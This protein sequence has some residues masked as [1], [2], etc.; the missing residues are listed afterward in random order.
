MKSVHL[1]VPDEQT[2]TAVESTFGPLDA[3]NPT[4]ALTGNGGADA[5]PR[6]CPQPDSE[7]RGPIGRLLA[8]GS[9]GQAV[10]LE[11]VVVVAVDDIIKGSDDD[12]ISQFWVVDPCFPKEGIWVDKWYGDLPEKYAPEKRDELTIQGIFRRINPIASDVNSSNSGR[13]AKTRNAYRPSLKSAFGLPNVSGNLVITKTG[14]VDVPADNTVPAGFGNADGGA[15]AANPEYGGSR[16]HIPGPV[17]ITNANPVALKRRPEDPEHTV[18]LGFEVTGGVLVSNYK[19]FGETL[20]GGTPRCDWRNVVKLTR[21]QTRME[22]SPQI[23][24]V[25]RS[26]FKDWWPAMTI[27]V[28]NG[29][30]SPQARLEIDMWVVPDGTRGVAG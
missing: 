19:T 29:L 2:W 7:G 6:V 8:T 12:F 22:E 30:S 24:A 14:T 23:E 17:S 28:V 9:Q 10:T 16:V 21:Y 11:H 18:H 5:G 15:V 20:D 25:L 27:Y 3:A 13:Q 1:H 4:R 26:Y